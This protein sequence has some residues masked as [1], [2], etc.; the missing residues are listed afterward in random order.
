[1]GQSAENAVRTI[2]E[3]IVALNQDPMLE[4]ATRYAYERRKELNEEESAVAEQ[5]LVE[6]EHQG[7]LLPESEKEKHAELQSQLYDAI[8]EFRKAAMLPQHGRKIEVEVKSIPPHISRSLPNGSPG[9]LI[10]NTGNHSLQRSILQSVADEDVRK[11]VCWNHNPKVLEATEH[12]LRTRH[13]V[14]SHLGFPS[15][16]HYY[17]WHRSLKTP[18][19][20]FGFLDSLHSHLSP[21][22]SRELAILSE[23]KQKHVGSTQ[24]NQWDLEYYQDRVHT[25][26]RMNRRS[27][28][29]S[30]PSGN[31]SSSLEEY[32][33]LE[34]TFK[35]A[36]MLWYTLF[37][38]RMEIV[39]GVESELWHPHV[40][41][42]EFIDDKTNAYLGNTYFDLISREG[43]PGSANYPL[44]LRSTRSPPSIALLTHFPSQSKFRDTIT[45]KGLALA[46]GPTEIFAGEPLLIPYEEVR[47]FFHEL[48]HTT[49]AILCQNQLQH[50]SGTRGLMDH[51]ET[52]SQL[53]ERFTSDYRFVSLFAQ[54]YQTGETL[55]QES[56]SAYLENKGMFAGLKTNHH[57]LMAALDQQLHAG[58]WTSS[59]HVLRDVVSKYAAVPY[60]PNDMLHEGFMHLVGY[61]STYYSYLFCAVKASQIYATVFEADPFSPAAGKL[62]KDE[63]LALGGAGDPAKL[64]LKL[65]GKVPDP[66][67]YVKDLCAGNL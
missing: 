62:Y 11:E 56:F 37:G 32:F 9:K 59:E 22:V 24:I 39:S 31:P 55:P 49:Q 2:Q 16:S 42:V 66:S 21:K 46:R 15:Y 67:Y 28:P 43:K 63:F 40:F 8:E 7:S 30:S 36:Q 60:H 27:A 52:P 29:L 3:A 41:K 47:T 45:S 64:L 51:I 18:G 1:M 19:E 10:I 26:S 48:G 57:L 58:P 53:L 12:L 33:T 20:I 34:N 13:T 61:G 44:R 6:F 65:T 54:H 50:F 23:S 5:L 4:K 14:A 25:E 38:V 35:A 17:A